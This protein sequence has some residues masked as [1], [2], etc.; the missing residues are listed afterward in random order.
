MTC[1]SYF[2]S[3]AFVEHTLTKTTSYCISCSWTFT[4]GKSAPCWHQIGFVFSS[5]PTTRSLGVFERP[6]YTLPICA[7]RSVCACTEY[8][9]W[10]AICIE[11]PDD[12]L[13]QMC[14]IEQEYYIPQSSALDLSF[15]V[16]CK[17]S[18]QPWFLFYWIHIWLDC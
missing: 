16:Y 13:Y 6:Y 17:W 14:T 18:Y 12:L 5:P 4:M 15:S 10:R 2:Q 9:V 11:Y 3:R 7:V 8:I 1:S